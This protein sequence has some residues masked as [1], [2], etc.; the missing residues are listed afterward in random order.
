MPNEPST[1]KVLSSKGLQEFLNLQSDAA[2]AVSERFYVTHGALY[3]RFGAAGRDF[4]R[5]DIAFHLEFLRP[6]LEFGL[7]QPMVDYLRWLSSIFISKNIPVEHLTLSLDWLTEFFV[8]QMGEE[9]SAVITTA[10]LAAKTAYLN[11]SNQSVVTLQSPTS[12]PEATAFEDAL[13]AGKQLEALAIANQL[14]D[15]GRSLVEVEMHVI[16][17]ALYNIGEKWQANQVSVAQEHMA[18]A[19]AHSVMTA[20]LL[21]STP[22]ALI[23]KKILLACAEGNHHE[24]GLRMVADAFQ[25]AG[26]EIEYLGADVPSLAVVKQVLKWKPHMVGLSVSFA[27]QLPAVKSVITQ[28]NDQLG[29]TRPAIIVGG[30]AINRFNQLGAIIGSNATSPNAEDAV[31]CADHLI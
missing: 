28:L 23:N 7:L 25:M 31:I 9:D 14:I 18:T 2:K 5:D 13:L 10:L 12:F 16:Q 15:S 26:W 30:L 11:T 8:E 27:H 24:V 1:L 6:V 21:L 4:C 17:P 22:P 19:I 29:N 20:M 3:E